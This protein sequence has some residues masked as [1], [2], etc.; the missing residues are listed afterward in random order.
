[1]SRFLRLSTGFRRAFLRFQDRNLQ[2][3]GGLSY[4]KRFKRKT[5]GAIVYEASGHITMPNLPCFNQAWAHTH[6][7][8]RRASC[9]AVR[10]CSIGAGGWRRQLP[11][12]LRLLLLRRG[13]CG[14]AR[15]RGLGGPGRRGPPGRGPGMGPLEGGLSLGNHLNDSPPQAGSHRYQTYSIVLKNLYFDSRTLASLLQRFPPKR[16]SD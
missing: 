10:T 16:G 4:Y 3:L 2:G 13:K 5:H 8:R 9:W 12:Q 1:M 14:A 15:R 7:S 11:Q 6:W